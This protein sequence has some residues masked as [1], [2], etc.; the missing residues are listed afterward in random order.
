[1]IASN[2]TGSAANY[3]LID[4]TGKEAYGIQ[5]SNEA[6]ITNYGTV[7]ATGDKSRGLAGTGKA[8]VVNAAG[9]RIEVTGTGA[10]GVYVGQGAEV[11]NHGVIYVNGVDALGIHF[12]QG[13]D[14]GKLVNTGTITVVNGKASQ[15]DGST[16][17]NVGSI[18]I[19]DTGPTITVGNVVYD[20][21]TLINGGMIEYVNGTLDFG[22]IKIASTEGNIGTISATSF[23]NGEFI[24]LPNATQGNNDPVHVIQYLKGA[25]NLPNNGTVRA[26]SHSVTWLADLQT[27]KNDPNLARI[28][29]V[30]IPYTELT[31]GTAAIELGKG[32][33]E[34][35]TPA[36]DT[37]LQMFDAIDMI[38]DK[39]ELAETFDMELRGN[40]Y[41]NIQHRMEDVREIF[42]MAVDQLSQDR[43]Y[44]KESLK[45]GLIGNGGKYTDR[46]PSIEDYDYKTT[47]FMLLKEYDHRTYGRKSSWNL[48]FAY[49]GFDFDYG[50]KE[51]VYSVQ[52]GVGYEDF[53]GDSKRLKYHGRLEVTANRHNADRKIHLSN[54][55]WSNEGKYW[56]YE[57]V[58]KNKL[59]Y[60]FPVST[61]GNV[62]AGVYGTL[63]LGYGR[64]EG[65]KE[66][67]DGIRLD[68]KGQDMLMI[69]PGVGADVTFTK[70]TK[71]GKFSL[72]GNV[73]AQYELGDYY[74][75]PNK[76]KI[77]DT[78]AGYYDLEQPKDLAGIFKAGVQLKYE[79]KSGHGVG[80]E[81]VREE[82]SRKNTR[83]GVNFTYRF[84]Q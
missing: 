4:V 25:V 62:K 50:S 55:I 26:I 70:Y 80:F 82:G 71:R 15:D 29:L 69:R 33:D 76:A 57:A 39:D 19:E 45:V 10:E 8:L 83:Y 24:V 6:V 67:G 75:G 14:A 84:D 66:T 41:A 74:D 64:F 34:I 12:G 43:I 48:G 38:S 54:G 7:K 21:P 53:I 17:V 28:V 35:Y 72:I 16:D 68:I 56:S 73:A 31:A 37:E 32:L 51:K 9:G 60:A 81:V 44:S 40:I 23:A 42:E 58:W 46:N 77:R 13:S 30:K 59:R 61:R 63:D 1:M 52:A 78:S 18:K 2:P 47:G 22:T 5:G 79:T 3:G 27:D 36:V 65:F 49:T 20:A 11:Q